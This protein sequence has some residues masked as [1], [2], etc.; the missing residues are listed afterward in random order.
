M[1]KRGVFVQAL[2][3]NKRSE[4]N[5]SDVLFAMIGTIGNPVVVTKQPDYAIKN[6]ALFKVS[7]SQSSWFLK[8][9]LGSKFVTNKMAKEAKGTT[10]KFVGLGYLRS[11]SI[12]LPALPEQKRIVSKLDVLSAEIKHLERIYQQKIEDV[13]ELKKS[14]LQ[15][16]FE[17][18]L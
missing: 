7:S 15:K 5:I 3:I 8:Y 4:V 12:I 13:E 10:Q 11:F 9:Y 1:T 14:I 2:N 18:E 17:G 16:A 6:V